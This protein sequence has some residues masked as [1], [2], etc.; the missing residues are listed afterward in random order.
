MTEPTPLATSPLLSPE[1]ISERLLREATFAEGHGAAGD[2]LGGGLL[3]YTLAYA[4]AA[5][6]CVCIG[7]GGGFVPRLM[8]QAQRDLGLSESTTHLVDANL[9]S[10]GW[11][12]PTWLAGE[13]FFRRTYSEVVIHLM[14][15][16]QAAATVF[17]EGGLD[18]VHIDGDHTY[19]GCRSDFEAFAPLLSPGGTL[20]LHDTAYHHTYDHCGVQRVVEELRR[21]DRYDVVDF[22]AWGAGVAIVRP[23]QQT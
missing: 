4:A 20:T 6:T 11:G 5:S 1:V 7:S 8:R 14:T 10:A 9:G 3:Y 21:D 17:A 15:S 23:R 13:S 19:E 2:F 18:Y 16:A 22:P 12:Q